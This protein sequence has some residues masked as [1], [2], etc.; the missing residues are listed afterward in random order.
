MDGLVHLALGDR[1]AAR[2][3]L[4][5]QVSTEP[6]PTQRMALLALRL[7]QETRALEWLERRAK[8]A[9]D[10]LWNLLCESEMPALEGNPRFDR[11]L[12]ELGYR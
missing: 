2:A 10:S 7:G 4:E 9:P 8:A 6:L 1:E 5:R 3:E 12:E 11:I